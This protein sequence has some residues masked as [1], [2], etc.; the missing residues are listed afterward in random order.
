MPPGLYNTAELIQMPLHPGMVASQGF[1]QESQIPMGTSG[2]WF[3]GLTVPP[4]AIGPTFQ[5]QQDGLSNIY[6]SQQPFPNSAP[7]F[8]GGFPQQPQQ[9]VMGNGF[10]DPSSA[11]QQQQGQQNPL[12][13]P[14]LNMWSMAPTGFECVEE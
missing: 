11:I 10:L 13:A 12:F 5:D 3:D 9:S 14:T 2:S 1:V 6:A 7:P 4:N 8:G